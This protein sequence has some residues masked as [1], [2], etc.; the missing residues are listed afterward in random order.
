M[1]LVHIVFGGTYKQVGALFGRERTTVAY[2]CALVEDERD[3]AALDGKLDLLEEAIVRL[4]AIERLRR[5]RRARAEAKDR[6]AA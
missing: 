3:D 5:V 2:A 6:A 1:Y 4:W